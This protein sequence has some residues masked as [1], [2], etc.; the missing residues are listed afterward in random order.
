MQAAAGCFPGTR[1]SP[2]SQ[3]PPKPWSPRCPYLPAIDTD[4]G[5]GRRDRHPPGRTAACRDIL[6]Q[7]SAPPPL[8]S[9]GTSRSERAIG[10][11]PGVS[12]SCQLHDSVRRPVGRNKSAQFRHCQLPGSNENPCR[13]CADLFRPTP[14]WSGVPVNCIKLIQIAD[15]STASS[16]RLV[17][18]QG[19]L[20]Y[21]PEQSRGP[22]G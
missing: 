10:L 9:A 15:F 21:A 8:P 13:N 18:L 20:K 16:K 4:P 14:A 3:L 7:S 5:L 6:D 1:T 11:D 17:V 19:L 22:S 12:S 2:C